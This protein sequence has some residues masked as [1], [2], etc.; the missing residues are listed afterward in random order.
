ML[1]C[2]TG[3]QVTFHEKPNPKDKVSH[4]ELELWLE[5]NLRERARNAKRG[6]D[7][8]IRVF[9]EMLEKVAA[10][11]PIFGC[12]IDRALIDIF[13]ERDVAPPEVQALQKLIVQEKKLA[14]LKKET[15]KAEEENENLRRQLN[16]VQ[17]HIKRRQQEMNELEAIMRQR[18]D[19]FEKQRELNS[20]LNNLFKLFDEP[21][22]TKEEK[23]ETEAP[24]IISL[25]LH[26]QSLREKVKAMQ[27]NIEIAEEEIET[28]KTMR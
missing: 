8:R 19:L 4:V 11:D 14:E 17:H 15:Q 26:N 16:D 5:R 1:S 25:R 27:K 23:K 13:A 20:E 6:S 7:E 18:S 9:A 3:Y 2:A 28:I 12:F 24:Q 10:S 22:V 21:I